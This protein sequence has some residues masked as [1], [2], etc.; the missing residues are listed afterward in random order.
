MD[1][2]IGR[3]Y[4][5]FKKIVRGKIRE[6]LKKHIIQGGMVGK[7]GKNKVTIPIPTIDLPRF[8]YGQID[9]GV[10][11]GE[12]EEGDIVG[13]EAKDGEGSGKAGDND[14]EHTIEVE[15]TIEELADLLGEALQLP[16]LKDSDK[17]NI[18]EEHAKYT[19]ISKVGPESLRHNKRTFKQ[20]L[21]RE[22]SMGNYDPDNPIIIPVRED[23]RYR[24]RKIYRTEKAN[25]EI[26]YIM[27]I[28]GSMGD[29]QKEIVRIESFWIDTWLNRNYDGL[30]SRFI[31]HDARAKEVDRYTFFHTKESGGTMISSSYDLVC[32]ILSKSDQ[33]DNIYV[34]Q[35]SDGDNWSQEDNDRCVYLLEEKILPKVNLFGYGQVYSP[36]GSG[37][38]IKSIDELVG[39]YDN[40][41]TSKIQDKSGIEQSI[42][43]FF[44]PEK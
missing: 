15:V 20:A 24:S 40:I 33:N 31:V 25:A 37:E 42:K 17:K 12:G 28:S 10:G 3:D 6:D 1:E 11:Q 38:F 34:F 36:Y 27:D 5:R 18:I 13:K 16:K 44:K 21:K 43:D 7:Q 26:I 8:K 32:D 14:G 22:I 29:E 9:E 30:K 4:E 23:K 41:I 39:V 19:S 2:K 35:F